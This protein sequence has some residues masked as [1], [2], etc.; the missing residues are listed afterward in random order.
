[1][2]RRDNDDAAQTNFIDNIFDQQ[3]TFLSVYQS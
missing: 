2:D 1:M 3:M